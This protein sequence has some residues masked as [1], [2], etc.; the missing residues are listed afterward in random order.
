MRRFAL[1][2]PLLMGLVVLA[3]SARAEAPA[4]VATSETGVVAAGGVWSS[5]MVLADGSSLDFNVMLVVPQGATTATPAVDAFDLARP[6]V[7]V[8]VWKH[9]NVNHTVARVCSTVSHPA[10]WSAG[11][12]NPQHP[13]TDTY[14]GTSTTHYAAAWEGVWVD[15]ECDTG[16]G[17]EFYRVTW[18]LD[19]YSWLVTNPVGVAWAV[20][21]ALT[22]SSSS[23]QGTVTMS[24]TAY[25]SHPV[26]VCGHSA[27]G[28]VDCYGGHGR[29][30]PMVDDLVTTA[31]PST[32]RVPLVP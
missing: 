26:R 30:V 32:T 17:H 25:S 29:V 5:D 21:P 31:R 7:H 22:W 15:V 6:W 1:V 10:G 11:A 8:N 4:Q 16:A 27:G 13:F 23:A 20:P 12:L 14:G 18:E 24:P 2:V 28:T 9:D 3:P 19:R